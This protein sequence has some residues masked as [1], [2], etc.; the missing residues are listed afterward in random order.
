MFVGNLVVGQSH[1]W[2]SVILDL[3]L[4]LSKHIVIIMADLCINVKSRYSLPLAFEK[5]IIHSQVG[6]CTV[7]TLICFGVA[8]TC[9]YKF[10][11]MKFTLVGENVT[12]KN[13]K[14]SSVESSE[15]RS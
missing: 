9:F 8:K 11:R 14:T 3:P 2:L 4:D 12:P 6:T 10:Y 15:G 7:N 1:S 13:K 5:I